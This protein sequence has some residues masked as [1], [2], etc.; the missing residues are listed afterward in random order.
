MLWPPSLDPIRVS[1]AIQGCYAS[2]PRASPLPF[3]CQVIVSLSLR[4]KF[5]DVTLWLQHL[6][7]AIIFQ[8][9]YSQTQSWVR[10][11]YHHI[12]QTFIM[13]PYSVSISTPY[14]ALLAF[15]V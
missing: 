11:I 8:L 2:F 10:H 6:L 3:I 12:V 13:R 4:H 15:S 1:D 14:S 5:S 9:V 7:L